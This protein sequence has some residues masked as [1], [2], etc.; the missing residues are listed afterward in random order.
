MLTYKQKK[1]YVFQE[2]EDGF[3]LR[4]QLSYMEKEGW[5]MTTN[6]THF[7]KTDGR[8]ELQYHRPQDFAVVNRFNVMRQD[9][10]EENF[11][12]VHGNVLFISF[13]LVGGGDIFC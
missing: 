10:R 2:T 6:G 7:I 9:V 12:F 5:G 11:A 3:K 4:T 13:N 8:S 1:C